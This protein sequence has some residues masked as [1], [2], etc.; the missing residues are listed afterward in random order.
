MVGEHK[1]EWYTKLNPQQTIPT[2]DDNGVVLWDSHAIM[3][4]LVDKYAPND[5]IYP[6][7]LYQRAR[8][9]Q[10]LYF[11]AG[12]LHPIMSAANLT[13][14]CGA[15]KVP[16]SATDPIME[17]YDKLETFL[18]GHDYLIGDQLT[19]ADLSCIGTVGNLE[20]HV[21]IDGE[22]HP[23]VRAWIDRLTELPYYEEAELSGA[24]AF[25]ECVDN[26]LAENRARARA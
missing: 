13:I 8:I 19:L 17:A 2:L 1:A 11:D 14:L 16:Q 24:R 15:T 21:P 26:L 12:I 22:R 23:R 5:S 20:L 9:N 4:Y 7:D 6:T 10:R 18:D 25:G 3:I